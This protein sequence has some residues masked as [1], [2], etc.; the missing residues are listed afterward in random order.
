MR[1]RGETGTWEREVET[2][3]A[4]PSKFSIPP[5][6][7]LAGP[8]PLEPPGY[9]IPPVGCFAL[10]LRDI[11]ARL[12]SSPHNVPLSWITTLLAVSWTK[13]RICCDLLVSRAKV[14]S[15]G[16]A[17]HRAS[18][19]FALSTLSDTVDAARCT[20]PWASVHARLPTRPRRID[21]VHI[22]YCAHVWRY[23]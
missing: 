16:E 23:G 20:V 3:Q 21:F 9:C 14:H 7:G 4:G 1:K 6:A 17:T 11:T 12:L 5:I 18:K 10:A 15:T 2:Q 13:T 8:G 19:A 22:D